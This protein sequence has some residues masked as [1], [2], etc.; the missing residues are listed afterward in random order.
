ML[1]IQDLAGK[2]VNFQHVAGKNFQHVAGKILNFQDLSG[3]TREFSRSCRQDLEFSTFLAKSSS[4]KT[5]NFAIL[6]QSA[7]ILKIKTYHLGHCILRLK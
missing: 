4:G 1:K 3:K 2:I 6:T 7:N 5:E